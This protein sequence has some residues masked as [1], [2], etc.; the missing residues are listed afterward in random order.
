[1]VFKLFGCP[2]W[3]VIQW[4]FWDHFWPFLIGKWPQKGSVWM[5]AHPFLR[6]F[7]ET[8]EKLPYDGF[9]LFECPFWA[10]F[11]NSCWGR[12]YSKNNFV[13]SCWLFGDP[14]LGSFYWTLVGQLSFGNGP[15]KDFL[16]DGTSPFHSLFLET[17][18]KLPYGVYFLGV[19]FGRH[20]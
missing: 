14:F 12:F 16:A 18:G 10:P 7:G 1:M 15:K 2:F 3:A 20:F 8:K 19:H 17:K 11:L 9:K 5:T 6:L 13:C 4:P